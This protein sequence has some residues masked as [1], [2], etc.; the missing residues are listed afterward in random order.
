MRNKLLVSVAMTALIAS[1]A[2]AAAQTPA[3]ENNKAAPGAAQHQTPAP[4]SAAHG[5]PGGEV[6]P[7][8]AAQAA[9]PKALPE[10]KQTQIQGQTQPQTQERPG[11]GMS[12][13]APNNEPGKPIGSQQSQGQIK[14]RNQGTAQQAPTQSGGGVN[15]QEHAQGTTAGRPGGAAVQLSQ[16]QRT[17]IKDVIVKDRNVARVEHP[18]FDVRI[19]VTV[20][21]SVHVAVLPAEVVRIVPEYR[22][23]EYVVIG[24][25]LLI[26]DP[27]TLEVVAILPA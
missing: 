15:A 1:T 17:Q 21:R 19:G 27:H 12:Q 25:Q 24:D 22:D 5:Q 14:E 2:L 4:G 6:K 13:G 18:D 16:Q 20:P 11:Q 26:I 10:Q 7:G 23:Y 3:P 9:P 8:G